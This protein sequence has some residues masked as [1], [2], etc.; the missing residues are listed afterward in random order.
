[1]RWLWCTGVQVR[2]VVCVSSYT[3]L[4]TTD[5]YCTAERL[6]RPD[7]DVRTCNA[8]CQLRSEIAIVDIRL[9]PRF[10]AALG[11]SLSVD[12]VI[13]RRLCLADCGKHYVIRG[14]GS[15]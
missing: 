7:D 15:T 11:Q 1:M 13:A 5:R 3:G 9:Q 10:G 4:V 6:P 14:T 2:R 8:D 12:A